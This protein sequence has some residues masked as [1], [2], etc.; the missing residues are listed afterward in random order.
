VVFIGARRDEKAGPHCVGVC[1]APRAP[2][3]V[4]ACTK[5][6]LGE[7]VGRGGPRSP[8]KLGHDGMEILSSV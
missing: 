4:G 6:I 3:G 7:E 1:E 8:Y 2:V 5:G